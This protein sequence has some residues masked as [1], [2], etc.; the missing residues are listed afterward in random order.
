MFLRVVEMH[1]APLLVAF[2]YPVSGMALCVRIFP[3]VEGASCS[4]ISVLSGWIYLYIG[5][6][7]CVYIV[8]RK[9]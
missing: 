7:S 4:L 8:A 6:T 3:L 1:S 5:I 9:E 2:I